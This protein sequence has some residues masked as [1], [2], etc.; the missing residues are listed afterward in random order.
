MKVDGTGEPPEGCRPLLI[1][2]SEEEE[3]EEKKKNSHSESS[4][5][6][7]LSSSSSTPGAVSM[8]EKRT[9][10]GAP[11]DMPTLYLAET[12]LHYP[13]FVSPF[14]LSETAALVLPLLELLRRPNL[15]RKNQGKLVYALRLL[16]SLQFV[17]TIDAV[18]LTH[19][20]DIAVGLSRLL[21]YRFPLSHEHGSSR[22]TTRLS[23][24]RRK[25]AEGEQRGEG[26]NDQE[27]EDEDVDGSREDLVILDG[28]DEEDDDLENENL[29]EEESDSDGSQGFVLV[30][31]STRPGGEEGYV[32]AGKEG[33]GTDRG[34]DKIDKENKRRKGGG[35]EDETFSDEE[36]QESEDEEEEEEDELS[37]SQQVRICEALEEVLYIIRTG[38]MAPSW[39]LPTAASRFSESRASVSSS[40][41]LRPLSPMMIH[42]RRARGQR[43]G[44]DGDRAM[45]GYRGSTYP[46]GEPSLSSEEDVKKAKLRKEEREGDDRNKMFKSK[47]EKDREAWIDGRVDA[48][49]EDRVLHDVTSLKV[50]S[51]LRYLQRDR[52]EESSLDR[53]RRALNWRWMIVHLLRRFD[54]SYRGQVSSSTGRRKAL[55]TAI[56]R[57][58]SLCRI[59]WDGEEE[60]EEEEYSH[61]G[62][63]LARHLKTPLES[64]S[65]SPDSCHLQPIPRFRLALPS[66]P[67]LCQ[68]A[69]H[70]GVSHTDAVSPVILSKDLDRTSSSSSSSSCC[71]REEE[72]DQEHALLLSVLSHGSL[73]TS[74]E[75]L[76]RTTQLTSTRIYLRFRLLLLFSPPSFCHR[77]VLDGRLIRWW[78]WTDGSFSAS[79]DA[80]FLV[81]LFRACKY[82]W[83]TGRPLTCHLRPLLPFLFQLLL[84]SFQLPHSA[85]TAAAMMKRHRESIPGEYTPLIERQFHTPCQLAKIFVLLMEPIDGDQEKKK[86]RK[87]RGKTQDGEEEKEDKKKKKEKQEDDQEEHKRK[88]EEERGVEED[89]LLHATQ[90]AK[91]GTV[92]QL[93]EALVS[94]L[95]V[96][97]HP[98]SDAGRGSA[99]IGAFLNA[100]TSAYIRRIQRERCGSDI[101]K[102]ECGRHQASC[103]MTGTTCNSMKKKKDIK[104]SLQGGPD[105]SSPSSSSSACERECSCRCAWCIHSRSSKGSKEDEE[106]EEERETRRRIVDGCGN[107]V[108]LYCCRLGRKDDEKLVS[109]LA[110]LFLQGMFSKQFGIAACYEDGIKLLCHMAPECLVEEVLERA[111]SAL[112]TVTEANQNNIMRLLTRLAQTLVKY[113]PSMLPSILSLTLPGIDPADPLKTFLTLSFYAVLFS[114]RLRDVYLGGGCLIPPYLQHSSNYLRLFISSSSFS[115]E[116]EEEEEEEDVSR[117]KNEGDSKSSLIPH[118]S[119]SSSRLYVDPHKE[120]RKKEEREKSPTTSSE[121]LDT[122]RCTDTGESE[123]SLRHREFALCSAVIPEAYQAAYGGQRRALNVANYPECLLLSREKEEVEDGGKAV[124][125]A[126]GRV[127]GSLVRG[128]SSSPKDEKEPST[129][130]ERGKERGPVETHEEEEK[131]TVKGCKKSPSSSSSLYLLFEHVDDPKA[132]EEEDRERKEGEEGEESSLGREE[133]KMKRVNLTKGFY[134][135]N[136][137]SWQHKLL[138]NEAFYIE[139]VDQRQSA[140]VFFLEWIDQWFEA[141]LT[142]TKHA[143]KPSEKGGGGFA[144]QLDQRTTAILRACTSAI[145]SGID[146]KTTGARL[147]HRF[148]EWSLGGG[149]SCFGEAA[150]KQAQG[151]AIP[152]ASIHPELMLQKIVKR[153]CE[154]LLE[155]EGEE[156]EGEKGGRGTRSTRRSTRDEEERDMTMRDKKVIEERCKEENRHSEEE[157]GEQPSHP[158]EKT[159]LVAPPPERQEEEKEES[160]SPSS[161]SSSSPFSFPF[162]PCRLK[163]GMH[164]DAIAWHV[165]LVAACVRGAGK[166]VLPHRVDLMSLAHACLQHESKKVYKCGAKLLRRLLEA[167]LAIYPWKLCRQRC[168]SRA[169]WEDEE[170]R[171]EFLLLWGEPF[172]MIPQQEWITW[173]IPC[174]EEILFA[175][176]V[177]GYGLLVSKFLLKHLSSLSILSRSLL[178]CRGLLKGVAVLYPD[179]RPRRSPGLPTISPFDFR[180]GEGENVGERVSL[181][182]C[183]ACSS[184]SPSPC[185]R[186]TPC[187]SS[188]SHPLRPPDGK[189]KV[190]EKG[191]NEEDEDALISKAKKTLEERIRKIMPSAARCGGQDEEEGEEEEK[192][193]KEKASGS[194]S[195]SGEGHS[196]LEE[197]REESD[198]RERDQEE[199]EKRQGESGCSSD[200]VIPLVDFSVSLVLHLS[201]VFFLKKHRHDPEDTPASSSSISREE[202]PERR[203][204]AR[205]RERRSEICCTLVGFEEAKVQKKILKLSAELLVRMCGAVGLE[206][207]RNL[208]E[209]GGGD[210]GGRDGLGGRDSIAYLSRD[211]GVH[212]FAYLGDIPRSVWAQSVTSGWARR[213][214]ARRGGHRFEG[215]RKKLLLIV[216]RLAVYHYAETRRFAQEILRD[217][218][219]CMYGARKEMICLL[220]KD[221]MNDCERQLQRD[222]EEPHLSVLISSPPPSSSSSCV[223]TT[224]TTRTTAHAMVVTSASSLSSS[225]CRAT[226]EQEKGRGGEAKKEEEETRREEEEG[227][228][229][230]RRNVEEVFLTSPSPSKVVEG[231][232]KIDE[233]SSLVSSSP[234]LSAV[235]THANES[236]M[237]DVGCG[238]S[239]DLGGEPVLPVCNSPPSSAIVG[240]AGSPAL[241]LSDEKQR[242]VLNGV[243]VSLSHE[244]EKASMKER[245]EREQEKKH[246][247]GD[248]EACSSSSCRQGHESSLGESDPSGEE[249]AEEEGQ[250]KKE[251]K[252]N[253]EEGMKGPS[254]SSEKSKPSGDKACGVD[255][256]QQTIPHVSPVK[257]SNENTLSPFSASSSSLQTSSSSSHAEIAPS[258][259]HVMKEGPS[260][261]IPLSSSRTNQN[262][263][264]NAAP[265]REQDRRQEEEEDLLFARLTGAAYTL[266]TRATM[267]RIWADEQLAALALKTLLLVFEIK[268]AK[269]TI[270]QRWVVLTHALLN[271]RE[272]LRRHGASFRKDIVQEFLS[273]LLRR[274][275]HYHHGSSRLLHAPPHAPPSSSASLPGCSPAGPSLGDSFVKKTPLNPVISSSASDLPSTHSLSCSREEEGGGGGE[276][277]NDGLR[278]QMACMSSSS[279][280]PNEAKT[281]DRENERDSSSS[282]LPFYSDWILCTIDSLVHPPLLNTLGMFA[283]ILLLKYFMKRPENIPPKFLQSIHSPATL[284]KVLATQAIIHH[285]AARSASSACSG[286]PGA[287][288]SHARGGGRQAHR[289]GSGGGGSDSSFQLVVDVIRIDR[290]W[291]SSRT[292]RLSKHF[293]LHNTLVSKTFFQFLYATRHLKNIGEEKGDKKREEDKERQGRRHLI[294]VFEVLKTELLRFSK[295]SSS[296]LEYHIC[297]IEVVCGA[298]AAAR[299]YDDEEIRKHLWLA[300]YP[301]M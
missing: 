21:M 296:E 238:D 252:G 142:L 206:R 122:T 10:G 190:R 222:Q 80:L 101:T 58:V 293:S 60:E 237:G 221:L 109:L 96:Y 270:P 112:E 258:L 111:L 242:D 68:K 174:E 211:E 25:G 154:K 19:W 27:E 63:H 235:Q 233:E 298:A 75:V 227:D 157:E 108:K 240:V 284:K 44:R 276:R 98:S 36:K 213:I 208:R 290:S 245:E 116:E 271:G 224:T 83:S 117:R 140:S 28:E 158:N 257:I 188:S 128:L 201:H 249:E 183:V 14:L 29:E 110:P 234:R 204:E 113:A 2:N 26:E 186:S 250:A 272:K 172:Y 275:L 39:M 45:S 189:T 247:E 286:G 166:C 71:L 92:F 54:R 288:A 260:E 20:V 56:V 163:P 266:N 133:R 5:C 299:K 120:R 23:V 251:K 107:E 106:Q 291:P 219:S 160:S 281:T 7:F 162:S 161:F 267:K 41:S 91:V 84:K 72:E 94:T 55:V 193:K 228:E 67:S 88:D 52:E 191:Y 192:K 265:G 184:L 139:L 127:D 66:C 99:S 269:D 37:A 8:N 34:I 214:A 40:S 178:L 82:G 69:L 32:M 285:D 173:H 241:L 22:A 169:H 274:L 255:T 136:E 129:K 148:V 264:K 64:S 6:P 199:E 223:P 31:S 280:S 282:L 57:L 215:W 156:E 210:D 119:S 131:K 132:N 202:R 246:T 287:S 124:Q 97:T 61:E 38:Y 115:K 48:P 171:K 254:E 229:K 144:A 279:S 135:Y 179:E 81:M 273:P 295:Y 30:R 256:P 244:L 176:E 89:D 243:A 232:E 236:E 253:E 141:I 217:T 125:T 79:W 151:I 145:F 226:L 42:L 185:I 49:S 207:L 167:C 3:E 297:I 46:G 170:K 277:R 205:E 11:L 300:L 292:S 261:K 194:A 147:I 231:S 200:I 134:E 248:T 259:N 143:S 220:L 289:G 86:D 203:E 262:S 239:L 77:L 138:F 263:M 78:C 53:L 197:R 100:L 114:Y 121:E 283:L 216:L 65:V 198:A 155:R 230:R 4:P 159:P 152:L 50:S 137:A 150:V 103:C 87:Y 13:S 70:N 76:I 51:S 47:G 268:I 1:I 85:P 209:Y 195:L 123:R 73:C 9:G 301:A 168:M 16:R 18:P 126:G 187:S 17:G 62:D 182:S 105:T 24:Q 35:E 175:K 196:C 218:Y 59:F 12:S 177:V 225:S 102:R 149:L 153:S 180:G 43:R 164:E 104:I 212:A 15:L 33:R 93:L 181:S 165:L 95:V 130:S 90:A 118:S 278:T 146:E 74:L 294:K